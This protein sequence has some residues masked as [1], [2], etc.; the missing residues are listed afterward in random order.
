MTPA[1]KASFGGNGGGRSG[2]VAERSS[3]KKYSRG[4]QEHGS[5]SWAVAVV[6]RRNRMERVANIIVLV[7]NAL[8]VF[9]FVIVLLTSIGDLL[10]LHAGPATLGS[11]VSAV[12][13]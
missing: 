3:L 6:G 9:G 2:H 8:I 12:K 11:P 4:E 1:P 10:T 13:V 7:V 5:L